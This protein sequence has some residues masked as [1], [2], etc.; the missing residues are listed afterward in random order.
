MTFARI[1]LSWT[2]CLCSG[3]TRVF[4]ALMMAV[5][6]GLAGCGVQQPPPLPYEIWNPPEVTAAELDR[7]LIILY[8]GLLSTTNE[9]ITLYL[10]MR[11]AGI[12]RAIDLGVWGR[13]L[14]GIENINAYERNLAWSAAEAERIAEYLRAHPGR[15]VTLMGFSAGA[16]IAI[17]VAE[18]LPEEVQ[19]DRVILISPGVS[20]SYDLDAMLRRCRHGAVCFWS[21]LDWQGALAALVFGTMDRIN[22]VP[23]GTVGFTMQR[24]DLVQVP[25][26]PEMAAYGLTGNHYELMDNPLWIQDFVVPWV[27][28]DH[29]P[30]ASD[31]PQKHHSP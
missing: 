22:E 26:G 27:L 4:V 3:T 30:R 10:V 5:T 6:G 21:A 17:W 13:F 19:L 15:P 31:T 2:K 18:A 23:A 11:A 14:E 9:M 20:P 29:G 1:P 7:G 28:Y 12:D 25:Y 8:P 24:S 16:A